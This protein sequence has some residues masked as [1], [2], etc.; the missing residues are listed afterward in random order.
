MRARG[1]SAAGAIASIGEVLVTPI[2]GVVI[3]I[4]NNNPQRPHDFAEQCLARLGIPLT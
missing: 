3:L 1:V 2:S 4:E